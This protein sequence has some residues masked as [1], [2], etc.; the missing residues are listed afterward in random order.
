MEFLLAAVLFA[1]A[2][3]YDSPPEDSGPPPA[4]AQ[5]AASAAPSL[6]EA[7]DNFATV[8]QNFLAQNTREG[9]WNLRDK[10]SKKI[11][12]LAFESLDPK[13][14]KSASKAAHYRGQVKFKDV[15]SGAAVLMEMTLDMSTPQWRVSGAKMLKA[16]K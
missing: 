1:S 15:D 3:T 9:V 8:V 4:E 12:R 13:T 10:R 2:Q 6:E 16:R 14:L 5:P 7:R 11:R